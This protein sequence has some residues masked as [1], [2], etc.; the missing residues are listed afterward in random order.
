M[1]KYQRVAIS[2]LEKQIDECERDLDLGHLERISK[3]MEHEDHV[4]VEHERDLIEYDRCVRKANHSALGQREVR[5]HELKLTQYE[6]ECERNEFARR[7]RALARR[8]RELEAEYDQLEREKEQREFNRRQYELEQHKLSLFEQGVERDEIVR[9][10][11]AIERRDTIRNERIQDHRNYN[12]L[13]QE[14][15]QR[16]I[17]RIQHSVRMLEWSYV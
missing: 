4:R 15:D 8:Q 13:L 7:E 11:R 12:Q 1:S 2:L 10:E 6:R 14:A 5:L 3:V 16:S 17:A 9:M